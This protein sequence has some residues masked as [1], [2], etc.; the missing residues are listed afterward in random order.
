MQHEIHPLFQWGTAFTHS[1]VKSPPETSCLPTRCRYFLLSKTPVIHLSNWCFWCQHSTKSLLHT[2]FT[3]VFTKGF[4]TTS[5][6]FK[7]VLNSVKSY[8][9][10]LIFWTGSNKRYCFFAKAIKKGSNTKLEVRK[11]LNESCSSFFTAGTT[12]H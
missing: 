4:T 9:F 10:S 1:H 3:K 5:H 8:H 6:V 7:K 11:K 12:L 2:S